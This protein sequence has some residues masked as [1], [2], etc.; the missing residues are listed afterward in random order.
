MVFVGLAMLGLVFFLFQLL[1]PSDR[2]LV[3]RWGATLTQSVAANGDALAAN[4]SNALVGTAAQAGRGMGAE[5]RPSG[6][7]LQ[8]ANAVM[9][10]GYGVGSHAPAATWG[11]IDLA[12]DG[13]GNGSAD[14]AGSWDH[15]IYATHSGVVK[16]T[17]N[18][19]PA[20]NHVWI[21]NEQYRTGYAH[22]AD[23]A[24]KGGQV[25]QRGDLI[26]YI[27]STGM[28][29][30]PHLDYQVWERHN[31]TWVNVNPLEFD[32]LGQ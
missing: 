15:P 14:P 32:V 8:A 5:A 28:S 17:P 3:S 27:G 1:S 20:G 6:N 19:Y 26:G 4:S 25:V 7:P 30:G 24:V 2:T 21:E 12:I 18:S 22:L 31:G 11:A 23:F 13:D 10:Q 29:S 9:T 16:V